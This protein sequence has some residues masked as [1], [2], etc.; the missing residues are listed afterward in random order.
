LQ[1]LQTDL[2][3]DDPNG[4]AP[5][6]ASVGAVL[7]DLDAIRKG[8]LTGSAAVSQVQTDAPAVL[9]S[10]GLTT[11]Q[12]TQIQSDQAAV[13]AAIQS[14]S[15]SATSTITSSATESTLQSVSQF[16]VGLPGVS[17]FGSRGFSFLGMG[18]GGPR[19][20]AFMGWR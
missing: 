4:T 17:G 9:T 2:S 14:S 12:L 6:H 11:A 20:G 18:W 16:L 8:T 5:T 7:D 13:A 15:S 1:T 10:M 3:T 19:R